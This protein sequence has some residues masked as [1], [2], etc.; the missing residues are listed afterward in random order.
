VGIPTEDLRSNACFGKDVTCFGRGGW[1]TN[2]SACLGNFGGGRDSWIH[3]KSL[4]GLSERIGDISNHYGGLS[5]MEG[6]TDARGALKRY[7]MMPIKFI[8]SKTI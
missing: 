2:G 7:G 8:L 3:W 4:R 5:E 1:S 6:R